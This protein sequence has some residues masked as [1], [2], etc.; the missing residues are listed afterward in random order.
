[1]RSGG[2]ELVRWLVGW[3][4]GWL[5]DWLI[6]WLVGWLLAGGWLVGWLGSRVDPAAEIFVWFL[7]AH[8]YVRTASERAARMRQNL[9]DLQRLF[10]LQLPFWSARAP[11]RGARPYETT[12]VSALSLASLTL[13]SLGIGSTVK[14]PVL[15]R[16]SIHTCPYVNPSGRISTHTGCTY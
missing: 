6:G 13:L 12:S 2:W 11:P 1:M 4:F 15:A 8:V 7:S 5:A 3:L 14:I 9:Q 16:W 10:P